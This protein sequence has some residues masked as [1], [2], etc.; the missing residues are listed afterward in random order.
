MK[1]RYCRLI[2][3][4]MIILALCA[5]TAA[6]EENSTDILGKPFPDFTVTDT[7][8][9]TFTLSEALKDHEAVLVNFW[10][11]WCAPC[12]RE[13]PYLNEAYGKYGDR[14]AFIALSTEPKDTPEQIAEY[15]KENGIPFSM[16]QDEDGRLGGYVD[17]SGIPRTVIVDRFGNAVYF[18]EGAF[19]SAGIVE[20]VLGA[21]LGDGYTESAVLDR[22]P[23]DTSTHAYPVSTARAI[24]PESG[25]YRKVLLDSDTYESPVTGYIVPDESVRLRIEISAEDDAVNMTYVDM[26]RYEFVNVPDM[27]DPERGVYVYDQ[28][29]P[30]A[31][32]E[33]QYTIAALYNSAGNETDENEIKVLLFKDEESILKS[34]EEA[35]AEGVEI[36]WEYADADEKAENAPQAY[37]IHVLDQDNNPVEEVSVN[38]CTDTACIPQES[39]ENGLITFTGAP[40]AY[41]VTIIDVPEGY[42]WDEEYEMYTPREY[43]EWVLHVRKD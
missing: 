8:G 39:D 20:R 17:T 13:F 40:D 6:A 25:N 5:G 31:E 9:N 42:S 16:G 41:H 33:D 14:V 29:M 12:L 30:D 27:L 10:A 19:S 7:E 32:A 37:I 11:T 18:H 21:F 22:I 43:G 38:F 26:Y 24:Y 34:V 2:C 36:R 3:I 4:V 23:G 1:Y 15:R 35:K 28:E